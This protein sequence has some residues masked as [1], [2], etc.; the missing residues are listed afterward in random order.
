MGRHPHRCLSLAVWR[1]HAVSASNHDAVW[2]DGLTVAKM[3]DRTV[4]RLGDRDAVVFPQMGLRWSYA[5]FAAEVERTAGAFA[6]L[7][8]RPRRHTLT[9]SCAWPG[10]HDDYGFGSGPITRGCGHCALE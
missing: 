2:V 6:A 7:G 3:L 8:L 9:G 1:I 4:G 10:K 5:W